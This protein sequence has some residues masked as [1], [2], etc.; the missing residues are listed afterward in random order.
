M[1]SSFFHSSIQ[2][3]CFPAN[4]NFILATKHSLWVLVIESLDVLLRQD[5][6]DQ[7]ALEDLVDHLHHLC[8][9]DLADPRVKKRVVQ[10]KLEVA[11]EITDVVTSLTIR[12]PQHTLQQCY[13][14]S[15]DKCLTWENKQNLILY[16]LATP[17]IRYVLELRIW[18]DLWGQYWIYATKA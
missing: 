6:E 5:L 2:Q 18:E 11:E 14:C 3:Q 16:Y 9:V 4:T 17:Y 7:G 1:A 10:W 15:F 12:H 8:L 13:I